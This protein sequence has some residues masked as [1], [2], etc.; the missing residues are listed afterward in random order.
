MVDMEMLQVGLLVRMA[1]LS[2]ARHKKRYVH[3]GGR[4]VGQVVRATVLWAG[5][6]L[7]VSLTSYAV[8]RI[9]P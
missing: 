7:P 1:F 4:L 5:I 9:V 6:D 2:L 3:A 8:V